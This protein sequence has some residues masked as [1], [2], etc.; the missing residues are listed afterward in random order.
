MSTFAIR[1]DTATPR[2]R[3]L[4]GRI[5]GRGQ[6][7]AFLMVWGARVRKTAIANALAKGGRRFWRDMARSINLENEG[8]SVYV[9][10]SHVAA[11][12]KQYGGVI[13]AKGKAAGGADC[14]TIPIA[15]EA[16]GQRASKF[17]LA[18]RKLFCLGRV[19]GYSEDSGEFHP[20]YALAKQTKPQR[21]QPFFP[22]EDED[23][24]MG[25]EEAERFLAV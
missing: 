9:K 2:L 18:G 25:L 8:G 21:A 4:A 11:A 6:T 10:A 3:D 24:A 20:L 16:K 13:R 1:V 5:R 22:T 12:Q 14:L 7:M 15:P 23:L 17:A 19:L